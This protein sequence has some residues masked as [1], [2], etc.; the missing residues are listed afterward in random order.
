MWNP[1]FSRLPPNCF[2]FFQKQF[3]SFRRFSSPS[4]HQIPPFAHSLL[5]NSESLFSPLHSRFS[6][7]ESLF[8]AFFSRLSQEG[9]G[10]RLFHHPS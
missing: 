6:T 4:P 7:P 8:S 10:Q 2:F 9:N 1:L 5:P 3:N